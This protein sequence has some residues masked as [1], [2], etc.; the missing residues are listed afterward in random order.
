MNLEKKDLFKMCAFS[1]SST[2]VDP[3]LTGGGHTDLILPLLFD[4]SPEFL[5][6]AVQ[7]IQ[8]FGG[9]VLFLRFTYIGF[10]L[11]SKGLE[12]LPSLVGLRSFRLTVK[13]LF[14][15]YAV[16]EL[17]AEPGVRVLMFDRTLWDYFSSACSFFFFLVPN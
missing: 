9:G 4:V 16:M 6:I 15:A 2:I 13:A 5:P 1:T 7:T 12:S 3:S 14:L 11:F 10:H 8:E 17:A